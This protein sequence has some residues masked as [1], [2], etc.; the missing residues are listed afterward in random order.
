M[1]E[2]NINNIQRPANSSLHLRGSRR[3]RGNLSTVHHLTLAVERVASENTKPST[4]IAR[5]QTMSVVD[6]KYEKMLDDRE[7]ANKQNV[8]MPPI[9][10]QGKGKQ[11]E[12]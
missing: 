5:L 10:R 8:E 3:R 2:L 11:K 12:C 6:R 1:A 7:K 9:G 4:S